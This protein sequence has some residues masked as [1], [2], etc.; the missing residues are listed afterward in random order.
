MP[1]GEPPGPRQ[2]RGHPLHSSWSLRANE[3]T[4]VSTNTRSFPVPPSSL[5][6]SK[7][8]LTAVPLAQPLPVGTPLSVEGSCHPF[9]FL[10]G[11]CPLA[12][13]DSEILLQLCDVDL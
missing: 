7:S 1:T 3:M 5:R 11:W 8:E 12:L 6:G 13:A 4:S 2:E 9:C 10:G